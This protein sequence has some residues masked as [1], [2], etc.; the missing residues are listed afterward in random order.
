MLST[1]L[2]PAVLVAGHG[3]YLRGQIGEVKEELRRDICELKG[4]L[5]DFKGDIRDL[6]GDMRR[7]QGRRSELEH[8]PVSGANR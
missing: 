3:Y 2:F 6:K 7:L 5:R 1:L 8:R 4:E